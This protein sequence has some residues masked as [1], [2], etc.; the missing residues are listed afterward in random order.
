[1]REH[2]FKIMDKFLF[3]RILNRVYRFLYVLHI[4]PRILM[5]SRHRQVIYLFGVPLHPNLG[6]LAQSMCWDQW[7]KENY[8]DYKIVKFNFATSYSLALAVLRK[9]ISNKDLIFFHS[10]YHLVDHHRELKI[11]CEVVGKFPDQKI[12]ILPQ[13]INFHSDVTRSEVEKVFSAHN[14]LTIMCRDEVSHAFAREIFCCNK[15]LLVPDVVTTLIGKRNYT[16]TRDGILFLMRNDIEAFYKPDNVRRLAERL[17]SHH[18]IQIL[19]TTIS[20]YLVNILHSRDKIIEDFLKH[21]VSSHELVITDRYHGT[22]F[23]LVTNT[24][25]IVLG[26]ADH[27]L[28]SGV[29][30]FPES[31]S[32]HVFYAGDLDEAFELANHIV[33]G[34]DVTK[35]PP[36]FSC[37]H[38]AE[39]RSAI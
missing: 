9:K 31:F 12:I 36:H 7:F 28:S 39:L 20:A 23:S 35:L 8:T 37:K 6:D 22:I 21:V 15:L 30:W 10:G 2:S 25:V 29:K 34:G 5:V 17:S 27:K 13:T 18:K 1:M 11:Y 38:Y 14:D 24:P 19:D 32:S 3:H 16:T 4:I 26:S 33:S